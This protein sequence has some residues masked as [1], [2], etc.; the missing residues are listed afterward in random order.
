[1]RSLLIRR[2]FVGTLVVAFA[3]VLMVYLFDG[4][5]QLTRSYFTLFATIA[6]LILTCITWAARARYLE[7]T[8]QK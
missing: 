8:G 1:M 3:L 7:R 6:T 2:P 5:G 4:A